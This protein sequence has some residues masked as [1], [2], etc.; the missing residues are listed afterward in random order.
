MRAKVFAPRPPSRRNVGAPRVVIAA[1]GT[2][3]RCD[4]RPDDI[5]IRFDQRLAKRGE[6]IAG[7]KP[8]GRFFVDRTSP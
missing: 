4:R 8:S 6:Q 2:G 5:A 3:G 7:K 1:A